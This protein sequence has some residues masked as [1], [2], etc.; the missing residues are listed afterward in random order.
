MRREL[1]PK[2]SRQ[3]S[4][5]TRLVISSR[6]ATRASPRSI[7]AT[8]TILPASDTHLRWAVRISQDRPGD[9]QFD[10]GLVLELAAELVKFWP[11]G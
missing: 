11:I 5:T 3:V 8:T 2:A 10:P 6:L 9:T 4:P 7:P 1:Q